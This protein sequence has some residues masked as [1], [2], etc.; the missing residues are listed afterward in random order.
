MVPSNCTDQ[1]EGAIIGPEEMFLT[2][3]HWITVVYIFLLLHLLPVLVFTILTVLK[4]PKQCPA[5]LL[6][7][8]YWIII[9]PVVLVVTAGLGIVLPSSG[10]YV[11]VS[12]SFILSHI[13]PTLTRHVWRLSCVLV[14]SSISSSAS[15]CV[16]VKKSLLC[17][18]TRITSN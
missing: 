14:L 2:I 15:T 5:Y 16:G 9:I 18:V 6:S 8:L 17:T 1:K 11:E 13:P 12:I 3:G 7:P 4:V 10:K